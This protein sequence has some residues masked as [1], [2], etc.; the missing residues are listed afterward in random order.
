LGD[1]G[2]RITRTWDAQPAETVI[3]DLLYDTPYTYTW[4]LLENT[5]N[6]AAGCLHVTD[7]TWI[8]AIQKIPAAVGGVVQ[9]DPAG[10][11]L[12]LI[13]RYPT[14]P[15][16]WPDATPDE[17]LLSG[18]LS[19][20][21]SPRPRPRYNQ[22][23]VS[24]QKDGVIAT[25]RREGT[26]GDNPAPNIIDP[27]LTNAAVVTERG[28]VALDSDGYNKADETLLLPLPGPAASP[29]LLFPGDLVQI[30]DLYANWR[31]QVKAVNVS[32][33]SAKTRQ[34]VVVERVYV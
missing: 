22:V 34:Q 17:T 14:S 7:A 19:Q 16:N 4:E 31:G 3:S 1:P 9:T 20:G 30:Q 5:W 26:A 29:K 33:E 21:I 18:I 32:A 27:L 2:P 25:I 15:K 23:I 24:G 11:N 12:R 6:L 13:S 28:R 10:Y 8:K